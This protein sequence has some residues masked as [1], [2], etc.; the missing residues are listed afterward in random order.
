MRAP[1]CTCPFSNNSHY[2][3]CPFLQ[4]L[5]QNPTEMKDWEQRV[6]QA[7]E[8]RIKN[9]TPDEEWRDHMRAHDMGPYGGR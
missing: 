5:K 2:E 9:R 6:A 1:N 3:L 8:L 7:E 4:W